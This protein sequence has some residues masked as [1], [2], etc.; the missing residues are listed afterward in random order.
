MVRRNFTTLIEAQWKFFQSAINNS[1][2][3]TCRFQV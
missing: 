3:N 2:C 1:I